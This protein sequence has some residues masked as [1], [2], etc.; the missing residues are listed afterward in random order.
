MACRITEQS[1]K[2]EAA[3]VT[4]GRQHCRSITID[5]NT[6]GGQYFDLNVLSA[7]GVET[8]YY[9]FFD[10]DD[11][12]VDPAPVGKTKIEVDFS[13]G[14]SV[15]VIA[16][17]M[18]VAI[19]AIADVSASVDGAV[20]HVENDEIGGITEESYANAAGLSVSSLSGIGGY[21][22][23]TS[24]GIEITVETQSTEITA[25][26]TGLIV[27]D[28]IG[29]GQ[30]ASCSASFIELTKERLE[31]MIA[32]AVGGTHT[33][34][35][36]TKLIG[37]GESKLFQSLKNLG[38]KLIL[39]PIRLADSD[40]SEDFVFHLAAPKPESINY[41]GTDVQALAVTFTA[42]LDDSVNSEINLYAIGDWKQDLA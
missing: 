4:W 40:R 19:D 15:S 12:S 28:E 7:L 35:G 20:V 6:I 39:H 41:S 22:G 18:Q 32:G 37:G 11:L 29:Q 36:G 23:R 24:E 38:G 17:A 16:S 14:D 13:A 10:E 25:N 21:L 34:S 30:T 1:I 3:K 5:S 27:L 31:Y 9:V 8:Q 2:L 33:P 42:Y 26:Q